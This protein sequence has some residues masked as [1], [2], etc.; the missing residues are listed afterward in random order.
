MDG[1][2]F[3]LAAHSF[4]LQYRRSML[5]G[6]P[7]INVGDLSADHEAENLRESDGFDFSRPDAFAIAQDGVATANPSALLEE[8]TDV[9]DTDPAVAQPFDHTK[10]I[11]RI[12]LRQ[13]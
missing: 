6:E 10:K 9:N 3:L 5:V 1:P 2:W 11:L 12:H 4:Q 8:M 7:G 13:A